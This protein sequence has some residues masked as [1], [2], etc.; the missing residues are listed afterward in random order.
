VPRRPHSTP[1]IEK[2]LRVGDLYQGIDEPPDHGKAAPAEEER[3]LNA[4]GVERQDDDL[5]ARVRANAAELRRLLGV[6]VARTRTLLNA[7]WRAR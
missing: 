4:R 5:L 3:T 1:S 7:S 6:Y 2:G